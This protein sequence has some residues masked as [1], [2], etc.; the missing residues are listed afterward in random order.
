MGLCWHG[1]WAGGADSGEG[2]VNGE[3]EWG[4]ASGIE[5][6]EFNRWIGVKFESL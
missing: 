1:W 2:I 4:V 3:W 6:Q 5:W